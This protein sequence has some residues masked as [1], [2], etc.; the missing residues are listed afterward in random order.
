[1][2]SGPPRTSAAASRSPAATGRARERRAG[3]SAGNQVIGRRSRRAGDHA[4]LTGRDD[5]GLDRDARERV[6]HADVF[7]D[8]AGLGATPWAVRARPGLS[9]VRV[10]AV[11]LLTTTG[12]P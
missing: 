4:G 5:L 6:Q 1:M 8:A 3:S 2:A 10:I 12:R 9:R 7:A 11:P